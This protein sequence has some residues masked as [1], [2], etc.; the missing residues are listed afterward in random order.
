MNRVK[1]SLIKNMGKTVILLFLITILGTLAMGSIIAE[2]AVN[3]TIDHLKRR[4]PPVITL[5]GNQEV[6]DELYTRAEQSQGYAVHLFE[7]LTREQIHQIGELPYVRHY[8]YSISASALVREWKRYGIEAMDITFIIFEGILR[9]EVIAIEEGLL[10]LRYG[11]VFTAE[12]VSASRID[13]V[14]PVLITQEVAELN[15]L[16]IGDT[17]LTY[18][19]VFSLPEDA[20]V[21]E[22]GFVG[23]KN[24]EIW[25]HPYNNFEHQAFEFEVIGILELMGEGID[26]WVEHEIINTLYTPNWRTDEMRMLSFES[27]LERHSVFNIA[28]FDRTHIERRMSIIRP[29]WVLYDILYF[30][31]FNE[32][33]SEILPDMWIFENLTSTLDHVNDSVGSISNLMHRAQWFSI[34][35]SIVILSL[36]ITLYLKDRRQELGIYLALGE[37]KLKIILQL[38]TEVFIVAAVSFSISILI[39]NTI[40]PHISQNMLRNELSQERSASAVYWEPGSALEIRGFSHD[41]TIDEAMESFSVSLDARMV[42]IY[43]IGGFVTIGLSTIVPILFVLELSPKEILTTD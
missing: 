23:L 18:V 10:E 33:A 34:G 38:L 12:E 3:N 19:E 25:E 16:F 8:E 26:P 28:D 7:P 22:G 2:N 39:A 30:D 31:D 14:A 36:L 27:T 37:K 15:E 32:I 5:T 13:R 20:N 6:V 24:E 41:I 40:T 43:L 42:V 21:P 4:L 9:P 35:A 17:F 29:F 11:R 1:S